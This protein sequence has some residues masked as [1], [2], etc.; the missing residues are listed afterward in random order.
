MIFVEVRI[1][2]N[3][4]NLLGPSFNNRGWTFRI[5]Y[6]ALAASL[7]SALIAAT[8]LSFKFKENFKRRSGVR[9]L[10]ANDISKI[11]AEEILSSKSENKS[12]VIKTLIAN[13][14]NYEQFSYFT[15]DSNFITKPQQPPS[16]MRAIY[17]GSV[18]NPFIKNHRIIELKVDLQGNIVP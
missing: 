10:M 8:F 7:I 17:R 1:Q 3:I 18:I 5:A 13:R 2:S 15:T 6:C 11:F 16:K 9:N 4:D 12:D 14:P